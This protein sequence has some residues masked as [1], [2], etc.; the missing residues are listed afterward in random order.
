MFRKKFEQEVADYVRQTENM[1]LPEGDGL[2][3]FIAFSSAVLALVQGSWPAESGDWVEAL[4][5]RRD[6]ALSMS[7]WRNVQSRMVTYRLALGESSANLE[8]SDH[9]AISFLFSMA[10]ESP[11]VTVHEFRGPQLIRLL[12]EFSCEFIEHFGHCEDVLST[13]RR[14]FYV[15]NT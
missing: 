14:A 7:Q 8:H 3:S 6:G 1:S 4:N 12:D 10:I 5:A 11:D 15:A 9:A 13:L 2:T